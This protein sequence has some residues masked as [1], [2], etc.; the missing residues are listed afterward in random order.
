MIY[1]ILPLFLLLAGCSPEPGGEYF[2][3]STMSTNH[4]KD[5]HIGG[6][7]EMVSIREAYEHNL[8]RAFL[9]GARWGVA[10]LVKAVK[11]GKEPSD[12]EINGAADQATREIMGRK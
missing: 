3:G 2:H 9:A 5:N 12:A 11:S 4:L 1:R 6:T 10:E 7:N 8:R